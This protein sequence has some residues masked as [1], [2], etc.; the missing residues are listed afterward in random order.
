MPARYNNNSLLVLCALGVLSLHPLRIFSQGGDSTI[1]VEPKGVYAEIDVSKDTKIMQLLE[2]GG[3][4]HAAVDSVLSRPDEYTPTL[5]CLISNILF[6]E[7]YKDSAAFWFYVGRT[8]ARIDAN[9]CTDN[10][11][12]SAVGELTQHFGPEINKHV[13]EDINQVRPIWEKV[14]QYIETHE[15]HY[16]RRWIAL[17]G[18]RA[19]L[20]GLDED[21]GEEEE[22]EPIILPQEEWARIKK[23]T[24]EKQMVDLESA[25]KSLE[26]REN[27]PSKKKKPKN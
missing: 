15:E 4:T 17:H 27:E 20:S 11:A 16:D 13:Y 22:T 14:V 3:S 26:E 23:E 19:M 25:L 18:M 12:K 5:V 2:N 21:E 8:R 1:Y 9:L 24:L 6:A 10:T 7:G